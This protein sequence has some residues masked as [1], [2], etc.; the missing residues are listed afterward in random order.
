MAKHNSTA[1]HL[2]DHEALGHE[3]HA[4][5]ARLAG[6]EEIL[7][8]LVESPEGRGDTLYLL[9]KV[10]ANANSEICGCAVRARDLANSEVA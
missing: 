3:L 6:V 7:L 9:A 4:I 8:E 10:V 5:A 1:S 2:G